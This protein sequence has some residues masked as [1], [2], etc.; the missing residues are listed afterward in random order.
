MLTKLKDMFMRWP[1]I[2]EPRYESITYGVIYSL[3]SLTGLATISLPPSTIQ[4][5]LGSAS[6]QIVGWFFLIGGITGMVTGWLGWWQFERWGIGMMGFGI[7]IYVYI[8]INLHFTS[9]GSR[10][11]QL[12]IMLIAFCTL[13][14]RIGKIWRY[15][16]RPRGV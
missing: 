2:P 15:P 8:V 1:T 10:L 7:L 14:L 11:S 6:I 3:F 9:Q 12:G 16:F 13:A 4:G 5:V